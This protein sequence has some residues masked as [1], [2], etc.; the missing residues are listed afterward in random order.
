MPLVE[1][2]TKFGQAEY[3][4]LSKLAKDFNEVRELGESDR[5]QVRVYTWNILN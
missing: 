3:F 1:R 5:V 4:V 2:A